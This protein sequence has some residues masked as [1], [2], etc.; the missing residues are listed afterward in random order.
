MPR[1]DDIRR[2]PFES[3]IF[4]E[5]PDVKLSS[6]STTSHNFQARDRFGQ[7][8]TM[9]RNHGKSESFYKIMQNSQYLIRHMSLMDSLFYQFDWNSKTLTNSSSSISQLDH[10]QSTLNLGK[11]NNE[12]DHHVKFEG[13]KRFAFNLLVSNRIGFYRPIPDTRHKFCVRKL[14]SDSSPHRMSLLQ[15]PT[16]SNPIT[17]TVSGL[18]FND[19]SHQHQPKAS[20]IICYYNEAPSALLRTIYTII[21]RSPKELLHEILVVDDYS[22]SEFRYNKLKPFLADINLVSLFQTSKREGLIRARLFGANKATGDVL[23]FLDSH[24]EANEGW[25]EPLLEQIKISRKTVACPMIDLINS[26]TLIYSASPMVVGGLSWNL[27]FKWDSIPSNKLKSYED[28]VQ[29]QE[30]P[31]MAGGLYAIDREYFYHLGE[32]DSGMN[33][34]GGENV[35]FSLR[36]WMC[37]GRIVVLPCSRFGHIFRKRRPY[38]PGPNEPD[39]LLYNSHRAARV[40]LDEYIEKFYDVSTNSRHLDSGNVDQRLAL[41]NKLNCKNFSWYIEN[42][43]PSLRSDL[44]D[45]FVD[46]KSSESDRKPKLFKVSRRRVD[47]SIYRR[48]SRTNSNSA[49]D[50]DSSTSQTSQ[51]SDYKFQIQSVNSDLCIESKKSR[52]AQG[53]SR[54]VLGNCV[55]SIIAVN[56]SKSNQLWAWT[57][58]R[59]YRLGENQCLDLVKNLPLLRRCHGSGYFQD[60]RHLNQSHN[61]SIYNP[62]SGL[63]LGAERVESGEPVIVTLCDTNTYEYSGRYNYTKSSKSSTSTQKHKSSGVSMPSQRWNLVFFNE[64]ANT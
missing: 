36:V 46:R 38:G 45:S 61:T 33:L 12:A 64:S 37:G 17:T 41:R 50:S 40:W 22:D 54:L 13:D 8:M 4:F 19:T 48:L 60:W 10:E 30:S 29:P 59:E 9:H 7:A 23:I 47:R 5:P 53:F 62:K 24:V 2:L 16:T 34:W 14:K 43:Y 26:E 28:F 49:N 51:Q 15:E 42:I 3:P 25:L 55:K 44:D 21:R 63:C 58:E 20:I 39:S 31:T 11:I 1:D 18:I 32:Y 35:E 27:H 6:E 52:I 57:M 56:M